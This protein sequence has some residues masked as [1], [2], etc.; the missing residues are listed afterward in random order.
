MI[1]PINTKVQAFRT[2][3]ERTLRRMITLGVGVTECAR[4]G[5]LETE[6]KEMNKFATAAMELLANVKYND[7]RAKPIQIVGS[8]PAEKTNDG[9]VIPY[10]L[11]QESMKGERA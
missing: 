2:K 7:K 8:E 4:E 6:E 5:D 11:T 1:A 3:Y 10:A 9:R